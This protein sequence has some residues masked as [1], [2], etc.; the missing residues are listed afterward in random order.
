MAQVVIGA[1]DKSDVNIRIAQRAC[2]VQITE[3]AAGDYHPFRVA[4]P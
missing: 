2:H 4:C 3:S 1:V